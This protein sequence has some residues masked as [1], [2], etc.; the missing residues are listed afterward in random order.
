MHIIE[1]SWAWASALAVRHATN[2]IVLHH[3]AATRCSAADVD[4]W[5][6][7]KGWSGIGYH[8]FVRKDGSVY[9]GRP[10]QTVGAQTYG[11]NYVSV[12]VCFEGDYDREREMPAAQLR[13]GQELVAY[14]KGK[15]PGAKVGKHRDFCS[16]DCPGRYFPFDAVASG[17]PAS[18]PEKW[19]WTKVSR[20][21]YV[22][23]NG[24]RKT[25]WVKDDGKWYYL[26]AEGIM[27]TGWV[28]VDGKWYYMSADGAMQTGW[29]KDGGTWYYLN[30]SGAMLTGW[31]LISGKWY[32]LR[33]SGAMVA[34][35]WI[36]DYYLSHNGAMA[37]DQWIGDYYVDASGKWVPDKVR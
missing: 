8:F 22:N 37:T 10:E 35:R 9:R 30:S 15:Y 26:D 24:K 1:T 7:D 17:D 31:Q 27:R 4:R 6:K 12:G 32:Y 20:W 34:D 3:A 33:D 11:Y 13:A 19:R 2:Y 25:G 23:D 18:A 36:G 21:A 14:L 5:H 29:I 16:T 28:K